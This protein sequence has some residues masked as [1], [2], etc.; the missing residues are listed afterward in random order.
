MK[1]NSV[2]AALAAVAAIG[3]LSVTV[4]P[5]AAR[6]DAVYV[7]G[8]LQDGAQAPHDKGY[9]SGFVNSAT[10]CFSG[11]GGDD[12]PVTPPAKSCL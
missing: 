7:G 1:M 11:V 4:H 8:V 2:F 5:T 3:L 6:A 10:R 12:E 9:N